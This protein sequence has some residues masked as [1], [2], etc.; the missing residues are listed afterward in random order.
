MLD[1]KYL[2]SWSPMLDIEILFRTVMVVLKRDGA[3]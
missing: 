1:R 2:Q 3:A